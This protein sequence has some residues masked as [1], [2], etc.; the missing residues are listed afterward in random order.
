VVVVVVMSAVC[1]RIVGE[2]RAGHTRGASQSAQTR[3]PGRSRMAVSSSGVSGPSSDTDTA[4]TAAACPDAIGSRERE[5]DPSSWAVLP[6]SLLVG[7]LVSAVVL[8]AV[9]GAAEAAAPRLRRICALRCAARCSAR[10]AIASL[11]RRS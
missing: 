6:L 8:V 9:I 7:S 3:L 4:A 2:G 5:P 11:D 10:P 1:G